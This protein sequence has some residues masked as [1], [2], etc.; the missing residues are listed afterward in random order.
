M[1]K[2]FSPRPF[3]GLRRSL[4]TNSGVPEI[5]SMLHA[6]RSELEPLTGD[7]AR[8]IYITTAITVLTGASTAFLQYIV[9][10]VYRVLHQ[11]IHTVQCSPACSPA[12]HARAM[13]IHSKLKK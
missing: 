5:P 11:Y 9:V 2:A 3:L 8:A 1:M 6:A 12:A 4:G 10:S 7:I 13:Q